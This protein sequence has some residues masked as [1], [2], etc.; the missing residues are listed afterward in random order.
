M[1]HIHRVMLTAIWAA[2]MTGVLHAG[3]DVIWAAGTG[4]LEKI[5]TYL[6]EGADIN[7]V[8]RNGWTPLMWAIQNG[9]LPN[10]SFLIE[11]GANPNLPSTGVQAEWCKGTTALHVACGRDQ[12]DLAIQMIRAGARTDLIDGSGQLPIDLCLKN[13]AFLSVGR[14]WRSFHPRTESASAKTSLAPGLDCTPLSEHAY[15]N[16]FIVPFVSHGHHPKAQPMELSGQEYHTWYYVDAAADAGQNTR[17]ALMNSRMF[18]T[19]QVQPEGPISAPAALLVSA[20]IKDYRFESHKD[21]KKKLVGSR[22]IVVNI[23]FAEA[24]TGAQLR[25]QL[26]TYTEAGEPDGLQEV[27]PKFLS[28]AGAYIAAYVM[29]VAKP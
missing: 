18:E 17:F 5:K 22:R 29:I 24:A 14:L 16:L 28:N 3:G 11:K 7:E 2:G 23:K 25:Q 1:S 21:E 19:V 13:G 27:D 10:A 9:R 20:E 8:D 6:A 4:K 15:A 12:L 26:L